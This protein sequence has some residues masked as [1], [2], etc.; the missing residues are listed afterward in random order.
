MMKLRLVSLSLLLLGV[1][2]FAPGA[3]FFS[4]RYGHS[5]SFLQASSSDASNDSDSDS[6][7]NDSDMM[8]S[9]ALKARQSQ[10][11]A[12]QFV[13]EQKWRNADC[14]S[15]PQ[16]AL[17]DWVRRLDVDWPLVACGTSSGHVYV[18]HLETGHI[19]ATNAA[20]IP[21]NDYQTTTTNK[22]PPPL[23]IGL[24]DTIQLLFGSYDGGGTLA[25]AFSGDLI[26]VANRQGSV[27]VWRLDATQQQLVFQGTMKALNN[28][29]VTCL[30]L[31][32]EYLWVGTADGRLQA[33]PLDETLPPLSLQVEP[34]LE[35]NF[36][37]SCI[38][39]LSLS[40]AINCGVVTTANGAVELIDLEDDSRPLGSFYPPFMNAGTG[41]G[42]TRRPSKDNANNANANNA[43][44]LSAVICAHYK[45]KN[46]DDDSTESPSYYSIA[47]GGNDGSIWM[48]ALALTEH[49]EVDSDR[50]FA[51][52]LKQ[53]SPPHL[54]AVKCLASPLPGLLVSG[55][56]DGSMRIWDV[57]EG[58]SLYQFIGYKV[59]LGSVWTDGSRLVSDGSDNIVI[60]HDFEKDHEKDANDKP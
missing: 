24:Q 34:E 52:P 12:M 10:L 37:K 49:G 19:V 45:S 20:E 16:V 33:Y 11:T 32:Q 35:W 2:S 1:V 22:S 43:H 36:Q 54:G 46:D 40:P 58:A 21:E 9:K 53:L 15:A 23:L 25:I 14:A 26:C 51:E 3:V 4:R 57:Q 6:N 7:N 50:P 28:V 56:L 13:K 47:C 29:L 17:G 60:L 42:T 59:W 18:A 27:E 39:S 30:Q 8:M 31:D 41:T 55:G 44:P 5:T 38:L 48:Q